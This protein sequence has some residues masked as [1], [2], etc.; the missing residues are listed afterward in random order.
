MGGW[1]REWNSTRCRLGS[2]DVFEWTIC[3]EVLERKWESIW[4][5]CKKQYYLVFDEIWRT[6]FLHELCFGLF[7]FRYFIW[8]GGGKGGL[9]RCIVMFSSNEPWQPVKESN[10]CY[11]N[12]L[13]IKFCRPNWKPKVVE[14]FSCHYFVVTKKKEIVRDFTIITEIAIVH[15]PLSA[16]ACACSII[17]F[18]EKIYR[19]LFFHVLR[20]MYY[21]I[22]Q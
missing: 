15:D 12:V 13:N 10:K 20:K 6:T 18:N 22:I 1:V 7:V 17:L 16:R 8:G 9:K 5:W 4:Y 21:K 14:W 2:W 11:S 3:R 19:C